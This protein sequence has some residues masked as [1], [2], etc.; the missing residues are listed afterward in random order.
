MKF[1]Q[2]QDLSKTLKPYSNE[3]VALSPRNNKVLSSGKDLSKVI[4]LAQKKGEKRPV[5]TRVPKN[6]GNYVLSF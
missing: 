2:T 5:V 1:T 3:W 6:Y 4:K